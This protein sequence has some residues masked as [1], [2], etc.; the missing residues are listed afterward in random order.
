MKSKKVTIDRVTKITLLKALKNG[1]FELSDLKDLVKYFYDGI[2]D[3]E[4]DKRLYNLQS[5]ADELVAP[6][7][8]LTKAEAREY[9]QQIEN[10]C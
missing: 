7:R 8:V 10:D 2:T 9:M 3:E 1:Y 4:L 6:A 5:K